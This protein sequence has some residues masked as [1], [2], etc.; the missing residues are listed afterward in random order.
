[1]ATPA[2]YV[3]QAQGPHLNRDDKAIYQLGRHDE[4][5]VKEKLRW[6][7]GVH[8]TLGHVAT[9]LGHRGCSAWLYMEL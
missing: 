5:C 1:M 6:H 8:S 9:Y 4:A 7:A 2:L 3:C